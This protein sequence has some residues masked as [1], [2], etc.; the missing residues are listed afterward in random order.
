MRDLVRAR[1]VQFGYAAGKQVIRHWLGERAGDIDTA[2]LALLLMGPLI[3]HRRSTWTFGTLPL[4]V[5]DE[6]LLSTW[7]D[8]C[9]VLAN[10]L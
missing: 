10:T 2:A 4:N 7:A 3:N 1:T 8:T 5:T 6:Q 9:V